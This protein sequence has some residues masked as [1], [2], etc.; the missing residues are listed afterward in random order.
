VASNSGNSKFGLTDS[1]IAWGLAI[2]ILA[3]LGL[4]AVLR[5]FFG[6][7]RVTAGAEA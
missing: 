6:S 5:H 2:V 3:A 7:I 4:L 1:G